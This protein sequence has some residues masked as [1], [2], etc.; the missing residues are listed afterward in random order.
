MRTLL[1]LGWLLVPVAGAAY[2]YGPGQDRLRLDEVAAALADADRQAALEDWQKAAAAY[3]AALA[4]IPAERTADVRRVRLER[5]KAWMN[6]G[7]LPEANVDLQALVE[8]I[9]ADP[10]ADPATSRRARSAFAN[11]QYYATWLMKLEGLGRD[12][13][14]PEIES[15]RQSYRQLAEEAES[16]GDADA[17]ALSREDLESTIRL[18]RMEPGDLQGMAIPKPCQNCKSGQCKKPGKKPG[19]KPSETPKDSRGAGAGPPPDGAGS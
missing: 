17:A 2:H 7:K 14:E 1:F 10:A 4:R 15:A 5:D 13:W 19:Q 9:Q 11:S 3:D 12:V 6:A 16:A 8:E 18:A